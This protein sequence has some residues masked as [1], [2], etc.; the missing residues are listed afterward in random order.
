MCCFLIRLEV[1]GYTMISEVFRSGIIL[2]HIRRAST[3]TLYATISRHNDVW[4]T[5]YVFKYIARSVSDAQLNPK[6]S[7]I[8]PIATEFGVFNLFFPQYSGLFYLKVPDSPACPWLCKPELA[9]PGSLSLPVQVQICTFTV[10]ASCIH[11]VLFWFLTFFVVFAGYSGTIL[12]KNGKLSDL[13]GELQVP[14]LLFS[15]VGYLLVNLLVLDVQFSSPVF[16][17]SLT[18]FGF[19]IGFNVGSM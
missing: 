12:L 18:W 10:F 11:G 9:F 4:L 19:Q 13:I 7:S 16:M 5:D 1:H 6:S 2:K 17:A 14:L 15:L 8:W 3:R